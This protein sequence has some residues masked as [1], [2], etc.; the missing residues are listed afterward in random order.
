MADRH[1]YSPAFVDFVKS[2]EGFTAYPYR[3]GRQ[4]SIG[5]GTVAPDGMR[6]APITEAAALNALFGELDPMAAAVDSSIASS[7]VYLTPAQRDAMI[8]FAFNAGPG[9][10]DSAIQ[11]AASYGWDAAVQQ[12]GGVLSSNPADTRGMTARRA[13]EAQWATRI[14]NPYAT[15]PTAP[16]VPDNP[17]NFTDTWSTDFPGTEQLSPFQNATQ[18]MGADSRLSPF[19]NAQQY[20]GADSRLSPFE[21]AQQFMGADSFDQPSVS[22]FE[23]AQQFMGADSFDQPSV[24]PFA[25]A[26]QF[27]GADSFDKPSVSPFA[28]AQQFMGADSFDQ[29]SVSP[30]AGAQQF[31]GADSFD[32]PSAGAEAWFDIPQPP[33][34]ADMPLDFQ[35]TWSPTTMPT[36]PE[37]ADQP[38]NFNDIYGVDPSAYATIPTAPAEPPGFSFHL[39]GYPDAPPPILYHPAMMDALGLYAGSHIGESGSATGGIGWGGSSQVYGSGGT[40][41]MSWGLAGWNPSGNYGSSF[42]APNIGTMGGDMVNPHPSWA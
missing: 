6:T 9:R 20:M 42:A 19:E 40:G 7:G 36:P 8:S 22:P 21:G 32:Q 25:G 35:D 28:G 33:A 4:V 31:M 37:V 10:A 3:D 12:M 41:G 17:L 27:M 38:L 1:S 5:Y 26:Q 39:T 16:D 29:P 30:F 11:T 18:F 2:L 24:S 23:G 15:V 13:A 14:D 34:F